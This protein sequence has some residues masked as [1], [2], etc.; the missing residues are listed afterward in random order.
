MILYLDTSACM[1]LYIDEPGQGLVAEAVQRADSVVAH[2]VGY[3][4]MRAALAKLRRTRRLSAGE[5]ISIKDSFEKDW[6]RMA[7]VAPTEAMI[8]RAGDLAERFGLRG[9]DSVHVAAGESLL[10]VRQRSPVCFASFDERL[11][12]AA[13]E[14]GMRL[15][16]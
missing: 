13:A 3:A 2:L 8:R 12:H 7:L 11:N 9:Y 5:L 14:L 4:E 16:E 15:L 1:K 6:G 10:L